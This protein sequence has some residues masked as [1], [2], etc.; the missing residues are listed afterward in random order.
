MQGHFDDYN[1]ASNVYVTNYNWMSMFQGSEL[2]NDVFMSLSL[3]NY[4][5][6]I[7]IEQ[8]G[9]SGFFGYD[10]D[11]FYAYLNDGAYF[12]VSQDIDYN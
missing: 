8:P 10:N 1:D 12:E 9:D 11:Y 3:N 7:N 5:Q 6:G 2:N 4:S